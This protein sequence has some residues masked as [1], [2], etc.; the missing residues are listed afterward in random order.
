MREILTV[1]FLRHHESSPSMG[2]GHGSHIHLSKPLGRG[3]RSAC[4]TARI[5]PAVNV[6]L[7][8][9]IKH[10]DSGAYHAVHMIGDIHVRD[11]KLVVASELGVEGPI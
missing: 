4:A 8:E 6:Q 2:M 3:D 11:Y 9:K 7:L 5:A 1:Q 10:G